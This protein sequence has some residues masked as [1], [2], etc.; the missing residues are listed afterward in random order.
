M[1]GAIGPRMIEL[2]PERGFGCRRLRIPLRRESDP[3]HPQR[4][5]RLYWNAGL[6][7]R[8]RTRR[9]GL[10]V[11]CHALTLPEAPNQ[12]WSMDFVMDALSTGRRLKSPVIVDDST[13]GGDRHCGQS[14]P[15]GKPVV[16]VLERAAQ[17]LG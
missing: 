13:Q 10:A 8:T 14:Q 4:V 6:T 7:L 16:G 2:A 12:V 3:T 17:F 5:D 9:C 15:P 11:E 1:N